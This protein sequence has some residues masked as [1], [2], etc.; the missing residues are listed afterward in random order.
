[1]RC[2]ECG[3]FKW[4]LRNAYHPEDGWCFAD[5]PKRVISGSETEEAAVTVRLMADAD[6]RRGE[7][8][9]TQQERIIKYLEN[10]VAITPFEAFQELGITKLATRISELRRSGVQFDQQMV[11]KVN[12]YGEKVQYMEYSL[13]RG[14]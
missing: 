9:M 8:E 6:G 3:Y 1:M 11:T 10:H 4:A 7:E 14:A 13:R 5:K 2:S 12:R